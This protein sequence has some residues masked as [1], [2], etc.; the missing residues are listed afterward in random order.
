MVNVDLVAAEE[1]RGGA[2]LIEL[3]SEQWTHWVI[4]E[5]YKLS[6]FLAM[7]KVRETG[8]REIIIGEILCLFAYIAFPLFLLPIF[9]RSQPQIVKY[10]TKY[11]S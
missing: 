4:V 9:W 8:G 7:E 2:A 10:N 1:G 11:V 6:W 5:E 3:P